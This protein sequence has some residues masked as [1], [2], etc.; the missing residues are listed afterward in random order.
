[1]STIHMTSSRA[2]SRGA[3]SHFDAHVE[4]PPSPTKS[5]RRA[6]PSSLALAPSVLRPNC[7]AR[8]RVYL[9]LPASVCHTDPEG[10]LDT[11]RITTVMANGYAVT[12]LETYGSGLLVYHVYCDVKEIPE[13]ERAPASRLLISS[14][15]ASMA[16]S[17]GGGTVANYVYSVRGLSLGI[18]RY[19][20]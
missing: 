18:L 14:F 5:K 1:M 11:D 16:G 9:W 17:Y 19:T 13:E 7:L 12:T 10:R 15:A 3:R 20:L 6:Y 8:E 4:P 2:T